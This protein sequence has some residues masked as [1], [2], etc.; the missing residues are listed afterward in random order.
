MPGAKRPWDVGDA[1]SRGRSIELEALDGTVV[2]IHTF[3]ADTSLGDAIVE[4]WDRIEPA[5]REAHAFRAALELELRRRYPYLAIQS[6][7]RLGALD[8]D[9]VWYVFRDGRVEAEP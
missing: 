4:A 5:G 2:R 1:R 7:D 6:Q 9:V 8:E 3:P